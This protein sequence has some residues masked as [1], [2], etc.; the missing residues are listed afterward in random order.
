LSQPTKKPLEGQLSR[1]KT[2][3]FWSIFVPVLRILQDGKSKEDAYRVFTSPLKGDKR[4][5]FLTF[6]IVFRSFQQLLA[7]LI[8][9]QSECIGAIKNQSLS[10]VAVSKTLSLL[11]N[12]R[13]K[14]KN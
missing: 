4:L 8:I 3:N 9:Y 7:S 2:S 13:Y 12:R 11:E 6:R 14:T 1:Q 10:L 5:P